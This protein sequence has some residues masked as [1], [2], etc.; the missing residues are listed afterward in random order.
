MRMVVSWGLPCLAFVLSLPA[1]AVL[2]QS[3]LPVADKPQVVGG[4]PV[5]SVLQRLGAKMESGISRA[6]L[7]GYAQQFDRTDRNQDGKHTRQ[8]YV[9]GGRYLT[10]QARSGIFR[11]ADGDGDG[12]VTRDEYILNRIITDEAKEIMQR[13]DHDKDGL[14]SR[15][16]FVSHVRQGLQDRKLSEQVFAALDAN[17]DGK[18]RV[19]EYLR[20]WGQWA[21]SSGVAAADR[22]AVRHKELA[23]TNP[24]RPRATTRERSTRFRS[25][26]N[27]DRGNGRPSVDEVFARFDANRDGKL[28]KQEIPAFVQQFILP[29]DSNRDDVVTKQELQSARQAQDDPN[30]TRGGRSRGRGRSSAPGSR[31]TGR[32]QDSRRCLSILSR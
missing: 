21:R 18:I 19:P 12:I 9:D 20:V 16:E 10:P 22:L 1:A 31:Q 7:E 30:D 23:D 29:A 2:A 24:N 11:A 4:V 15:E 32:P 28:Q 5:T 8:E 26:R 3:S 13:M 17:N 6:A 25:N 27:P 14:V